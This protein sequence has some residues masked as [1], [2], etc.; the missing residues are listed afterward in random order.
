MST[1]APA[2]GPAS[3][4]AMRPDAQ[5]LGRSCVDPLQ[6]LGDHAAE[7]RRV[8][9]IGSVANAG[10]RSRGSAS[11]ARQAGADLA[12]LSSL[13]AGGN[14][15]SHGSWSLA[16]AMPLA[17]GRQSGRSQPPARSDSACR[18]LRPAARIGSPVSI[19]LR[20]KNAPGVPI[21]NLRSNPPG[22][23]AVGAKTARRRPGLGRLP[24]ATTEGGGFPL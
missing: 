12:A 9:A 18:A 21:W 6:A 24:C 19:L 7:G 16:P 4:S 11:P 10:I 2:I 15:Q 1:T 8:A 22:A 5:N 23:A 20:L 13:P 3:G 14:C 17:P